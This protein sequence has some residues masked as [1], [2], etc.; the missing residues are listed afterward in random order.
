MSDWIQW[1]FKG[2]RMK[3]LGDKHEESSESW[4]GKTLHILI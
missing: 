1:E 2:G 3:V 4:R